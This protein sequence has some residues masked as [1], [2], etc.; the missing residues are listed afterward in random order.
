MTAARRTYVSMDEATSKSP[1]ETNLR[2]FSEK[3]SRP[4]M[5]VHFLV[6]VS[7]SLD[8]AADKNSLTSSAYLFFFSEARHR[9][10]CE[11]EHKPGAEEVPIVQVRRRRRGWARFCA[12]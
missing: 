11:Q 4:L 9:Q 12:S 10:A 7:W 5:K 1:G 2:S 3:A 8:G 6:L